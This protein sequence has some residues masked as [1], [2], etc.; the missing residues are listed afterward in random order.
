MPSNGSLKVV[1]VENQ[2]LSDARHDI[3][4]MLTLLNLYK[5]ITVLRCAINIFAKYDASIDCWPT[6]YLS[7]VFSTSLTPAVSCAVRSEAS[8]GN[9]PQGWRQLDQPVR[10][11]E[12]APHGIPLVAMTR[13]LKAT[14]MF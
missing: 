7:L 5:C 14:S 10:T 9:Q 1:G 4:L 2:M 8:G 11:H 13:K 6:E 3:L 12:K